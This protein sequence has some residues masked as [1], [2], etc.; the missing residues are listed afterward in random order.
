M[1]PF[2]AFNKMLVQTTNISSGL[3]LA[4]GTIGFVSHILYGIVWIRLHPADYENL[5]LRVAGTLTCLLLLLIKWWP[6][7]MK[8]YLPWYWFFVVMYTLPFFSTY[9]LLASNYAI[10]R[11]MMMMAML[12]ILITVLPHPVVLIVNLIVGMAAGIWWAYQTMPNFASL[13]HDQLSTIY[14]PMFVFTIGTSLIFSRSN[15]K[16]ILAQER[17]KAVEALA[18]AGS[19]AHEIRSP[20]GQ[21]KSSLSS[22]GQRLPQPSTNGQAQSINPKDLDALYREL[23]QSKIAIERGLQVITMTL[24]E[25]HARPIDPAGLTYLSAAAATRKAVEEFSYEG[26]AE[27]EK[28]TIDVVRD[29]TFRGDETRYVFILFNLLKNAAYYFKQ[30]PH[31]RVSITIA[32]HT[33]AVHDTGPGMN[34]Q[35]LARLFE[36]FHTAGK[37]GGTGLGLAFC[38]RTMRAFGGDISCESV[39]GRFTRF[40]LSFPPVSDADLADHSRNVQERAIALFH[41]KRLLIVDDVPALRQTARALL[42]PLG[43]QMDEAE[44]G[45]VALRMLERT[46]Y[47]AVVLDLSMPVQDGYATA[48]SIRSGAIAGREHMPIVAYTA[49]SPHSARIKLEKV[50]VTAF[51]Q[52]PCGQIDL[53]DALCRAVE[54]GE[55]R[56][57]SA[58]ASASLAGK[59][60]LLADDQAFNRKFLRALLQERGVHVLEAGTGQEVLDRLCGATHVDAVLT[61]IN[62]PGLNGLEVTRA[63]RAMPAPHGATPVIALT[64]HSDEAMVEAARAAG[65]NDFVVKP[66]EPADFF[67]KLSR[68]VLANGAMRVPV[69]SLRAPAAGPAG[70]ESLLDA[71]RLQA[72]LQMD[73]VQS[74]LDD[75]G[76]LL[77][78]LDACVQDRNFEEMREVMHSL[79]G[80]AGEMGARALH[81]KLRS[82]YAFIAEERQWPAEEDWLAHLHALYAQTESAMR[83]EYAEDKVAIG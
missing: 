3:I 25:V 21:L 32:D 83:A 12:F 8:R 30:Y 82:L 18:L 2:A 80:I 37:A 40:I 54:D 5:W 41:G 52:K 16:G 28:V 75:T 23:A 53:L 76:V 62:M 11:S 45:E 73:M 27:R 47:D 31:A 57:S 19:I 17:I 55:R 51:V 20:L 60:I 9:H 69:A 6:P 33:V 72:M 35:A 13:G 22:I 26:P 15:L 64:A 70:P 68:Q 39:Q 1:N 46:G 65:M 49:E 66:V 50:G 59:T 81:R 67:E 78:K 42:E 38:R 4:V 7:A 36:P 10:M 71:S 58:R 24:D 48:A 14:L 61:D 29:F 44:N 43:A 56:A 77:R 34:P 74:A 63:I 79:V